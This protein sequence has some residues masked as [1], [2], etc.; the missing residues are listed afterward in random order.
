MHHLGGSQLARFLYGASLAA[1]IHSSIFNSGVSFVLVVTFV[2]FIRCCAYA[3]G[4]PWLQMKMRE[5]SR[6]QA[7]KRSLVWGLH[8]TLKAAAPGIITMPIGCK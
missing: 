7:E 5:A 6:R 4:V 3:C 8:T 2:Y 1:S